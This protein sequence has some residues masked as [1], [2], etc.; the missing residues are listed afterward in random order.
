MFQNHLWFH[1]DQ[2]FMWGSTRHV[3]F[4]RIMCKFSDWEKLTPGGGL[5]RCPGSQVL[6][7][8][9]IHS[10]RLSI[11]ARVKGGGEILLNSKSLAHF[12]RKCRCEP[13]ITVRDDSFGKSEPRYEVFQIFEGYT[14]SVDRF[15]AWD[16]F[17]CFGTTLIHNRK[18]GVEA[19]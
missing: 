5:S 17:S 2:K 13:G 9:C 4:P 3:V 15:R 6:F 16:E 10:F 7:D 18:N 14:C 19:L 11:S 1:A 12:F 8:P